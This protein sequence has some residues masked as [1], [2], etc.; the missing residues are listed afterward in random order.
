MNYW[1]HNNIFMFCLILFLQVNVL[2][3]AQRGAV[4]RI[5]STTDAAQEPS[6]V[7]LD[8]EPEFSIVAGEQQHI[9]LTFLIKAGYHIQANRVKDE[10]LIPTTL[11]MDASDT[12]ILG[13]P[14]FPEAVEFSMKGKEEALHVYSDVL[15]IQVPI[16]TVK[17][18][19]KGEF[20]IH[21]KLHYQ[22]CDETKCYFP[23]DL[24]FIMKI[25]IQ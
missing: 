1:L 12:L 7:Q 14:I 4:Q 11:S 10:N 8:R 18:V 9:S 5:V 20:P 13:N 6:F 16:K 24:D 3:H 2:V 22:A 19:E 23:R 15:E 17:F 21:G 25:H